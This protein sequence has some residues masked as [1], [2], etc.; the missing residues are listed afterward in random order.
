MS[1]ANVTSLEAARCLSVLESATEPIVAADLA[2]RMN[3]P[4]C[5]ESRR[6]HVRAIIKSLRDR[7]EKIIATLQGGYWLTKDEGLWR[8]YLEGRQVDAKRI[9]ADT[10]K[11][12]RMQTGAKGQGMLF[13]PGMV[14]CGVAKMACVV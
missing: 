6:R 5:R 13:D 14:C 11:K 9:L 3:L 4:G 8:D 1:K 12:K 2:A 10:H 7:G